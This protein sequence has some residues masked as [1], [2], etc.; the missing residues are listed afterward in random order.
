MRNVLVR[1][2][3]SA[4]SSDPSIP[5]WE[6]PARLGFDED[7]WTWLFGPVGL[8]GPKERNFETDPASQTERYSLRLSSGVLNSPEG[9]G[10]LEFDKIEIVFVDT[11]GETQ[12]Q[13]VVVGITNQVVQ[14]KS[15]ANTII[16]GGDG[17]RHCIA[18]R[19]PL[20]IR[21]AVNASHPSA[22]FSRLRKTT[23]VRMTP[24]IS[25]P[26]PVSIAGDNQAWQGFNYDCAPTPMQDFYGW[27]DPGPG[28]GFAIGFLVGFE[29][30]AKLAITMCDATQNRH[31]V[32]CLD[33]STGK[34]MLEIPPQI[35]YGWWHVWSENQQI[36]GFM[37]PR[38]NNP[39]WWNEHPDPLKRCTYANYAAGR[40]V[41]DTP[42]PNNLEHLRRTTGPLEVLCEQYDDQMARLDLRMVRADLMYSFKKQIED[43]YNFAMNPA[44]QGT[45]HVTLGGRGPSWLGDTLLMGPETI[46][47]GRMLARTI[48]L[49]QMKN[50][51]RNRT[52]GGSPDPH[53]VSSE[54]NH[55]L[56]LNEDSSQQMEEF[57]TDYFLGR[58]GE[59]E[60]AKKHLRAWFV[61]TPAGEDTEVC[62]FDKF[63]FAPKFL[64]VTRD[65]V[66][67]DRAENWSCKPDYFS[68]MAAGYGAVIDSENAQHYIEKL[69]RM[70]SPG[71]GRTGEQ[72]LSYLKA[73]IGKEQ[74]A[75]SIYALERFI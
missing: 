45:G 53:V 13:T 62:Y 32:D 48:A 49:L 29:A 66:P 51:C 28:S 71:T 40:Y 19:N 11:P 42:T 7:S 2:W 37:H 25:I 17:Q 1:V 30:S 69:K 15:R 72:M 63:G 56:P 10:G 65:G 23:R 44:N 14:I 73:E 57:I 70:P 31:G 4:R 46:R 54:N 64:G 60:A 18:A 26:L 21:C 67:L 24:N 50:T 43:W 55:P 35:Y 6:R 38:S 22:V 20:R 75:L 27:R 5:A 8:H 12:V 16:I 61:T 47:H 58:A 9:R 68:L 34:P 52:R 39:I 36:K 41:Y 59:I 3:D 33:W 74:T